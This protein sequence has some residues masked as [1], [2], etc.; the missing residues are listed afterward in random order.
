MRVLSSSEDG[1]QFDIEAPAPQLSP[2][3][4]EYGYFDQVRIPGLRQS[5]VEGSPSLPLESYLIALPPGALPEIRILN[6]ESQIIEG[7]NVLPAAS[8]HL[9]SDIPLSVDD[10]RDFV[11]DVTYDYRPDEKIFQKDTYYPASP[12]TLG[13]VFWIRNNRVV[14]IYVNPVLVNPV[15]GSLK[16]FTDLQVEILF[17]PSPEAMDLPPAAQPEGSAFSSILSRTLLN[18]DESQNWRL[19]RPTEVS[20]QVSPCLLDSSPYRLAVKETGIYEVSWSELNSAGW[21]ANPLI[22]E[23]RMCSGGSEIA[24]DIRDGNSNSLFD[25]SDSIVFYGQS[26]KTQETSTNIYWLSYAAGSSGMRMAEGLDSAGTETPDVYTATYHLETDAKYYTLI[27][28]TDDS[29]HWFW[30]EG[31]HGQSGPDTTQ[32][33]ETTTFELHNISSGD[34]RIGVQLWGWDTSTHTTNPYHRVEVFIN[35]HSLGPQDFFGLGAPYLYEA[36]F[37]SSYLQ[38]GTNSITVRSLEHDGNWHLILL[39]WID[40]TLQRSFVAVEGHLAFGFD[41]SGNEDLG[42][43]ASGFAPGL[44]VE[45]YDVTDV[46]SPTLQQQTT[47]DGSLSFSRMISGTAALEMIEAGDYLSPVSIIPDTLPST[48]LSDSNNSADMIII[49]DPSLNSALDPLRTLR[50]NQGLSV[51]TVFVQDIFNEFNFGIY[52]TEAIKDFLN[53]A[54]DNWTGSREYVLLAGEGSYDHRDYLGL[55]GTGGDLVPVYL[56]SGVDPSIGETAA[57]N[58]YVDFDHDDLADMLLGRL[59]ARDSAELAVMV[60]KIFSYE[61]TLTAPIWRAKHIFVTDDGLK[62]DVPLELPCTTTDPAGDFHLAVDNFLEAYFP[63]DNFLRRISYAPPPCYADEE[64]YYA[65]TVLEMQS[66][67]LNQFNAGSQFVIYTGHSGPRRWG[68]ETFLDSQLASVLSNGDRTP[69]MLPMTCFVGRYHEPQGDNLSET[70]LKL[71]SGG[72]VASYAPT[73]AQVQHGH[74]YLLQGFYS[75]VFSETDPVRVLGEAV[76]LAKLSLDSAISYQDL[77]NTFMLLGDPAMRLDLPKN[78]ERSFIPL[79]SR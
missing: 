16:H 28:M 67:I 62:P 72:S 27:P 47:T 2:I 5:D 78:L 7:V 22:N 63:G 64:S 38:E 32:N 53:F 21:T 6:S 49:T 44:T 57:D 60:G 66:T 30:R 79:S 9:E 77:H 68:E 11:P 3:Q 33:S 54:F 45:I 12:V 37:D 50:T 71:A 70:I 51:K 76:Y 15:E 8:Q 69:I 17:K 61:S 25:G 29:D 39:D 73:G 55:N 59:P 43:S 31:L 4:T 34:A 65:S 41:T 13:D 36:E 19:R 26:I 24:I 40:V 18:Y 75:G 14:R 20:P 74:D 1:I 42:F 35:G 48:L 56:K 10:L 52:S 46:I 58:Q 23:L